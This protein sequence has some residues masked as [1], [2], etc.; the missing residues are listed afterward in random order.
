MVRVKR[1]ATGARGSTNRG[2]PNPD[3]QKSRTGRPKRPRKVREPDAL[4]R[5]QSAS[6]GRQAWAI[7]GT[8]ERCH[9]H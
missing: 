3:A 4:P 8:P 2:L 1:S 9:R 7:E 6:A 5:E